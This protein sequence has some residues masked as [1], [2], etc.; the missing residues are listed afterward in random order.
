MLQMRNL[1]IDPDF[2]FETLGCKDFSPKGI[3]FL[4]SVLNK[5]FPRLK[6]GYFNLPKEKF[7][8]FENVVI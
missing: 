5:E 8:K 1:N 6:I 7:K 2:Y 4:V 3:R